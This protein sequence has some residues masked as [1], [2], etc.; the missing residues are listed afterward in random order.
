MEVH[1]EALKWLLYES[2]ISIS[3]I[4]RACRMDRSLI[5]DIR[6]R[7]FDFMHL[8][9]KHA[10]DL[11]AY[12]EAIRGAD[13]YADR[14]WVVCEDDQMELYEYEELSTLPQH[15]ELISEVRLTN[16]IANFEK[17]KNIRKKIPPE[18]AQT[19]VDDR[20]HQAKEEAFR[21][22]GFNKKPESFD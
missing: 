22:V 20:Y 9:L 4:A 15:A 7:K 16:E 6:Q 13:Y 21:S 5:K 14:R 19:Y 1:L 11:I 3:A 18:E 17:I 12:A 10:I 2:T 8:E